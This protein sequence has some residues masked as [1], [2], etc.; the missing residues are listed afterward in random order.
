M[1]SSV[2]VHVHA[3]SIILILQK[4]DICV[5]AYMCCPCESVTDI[6]RAVIQAPG[7]STCGPLV[8]ALVWWCNA[9][10]DIIVFC[11]TL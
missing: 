10:S 7:I 4:F 1:L 9:R 3:C 5:K 6:I 11:H 2:H 8:L